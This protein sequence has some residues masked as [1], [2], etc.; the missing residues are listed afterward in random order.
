MYTPSGSSTDGAIAMETKNTVIIGI[1]NPIMSDDGVGVAVARRLEDLVRAPWV[2]VV[3]GS[4]Y[5]PDLLPVLEGRKKAIFIDA[6][7]MKDTEAGAVFRFP[8]DEGLLLQ[9]SNPLSL[10]DF[11]VAELIATAKL[12]DSC[13]PEIVLYAI[14]VKNVSLG[15]QL[16]SEVESAVDRVCS[17]ILEELLPE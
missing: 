15:E 11:G 12:L 16:S 8:F 9:K 13:P 4:I 3:E 7:D 14:Q 10:H 6:V 5:S 17:L 1:G 2:E